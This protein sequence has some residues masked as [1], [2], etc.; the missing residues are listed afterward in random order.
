MLVLGL[1]PGLA[2]TG[3][4]LVE[5][6]GQNLCPVTYGVIR[7]PA[8]TPLADRLVELQ[9]RLEEII[10]SYRPEVAAV[11]EL[12]FSTNVRT[13]I[14]V[15]QARG[16]ALLTVARAGLRVVEYTPMQIKQGITGYGKADKLQVQRMVRLLLNLDELPRPDDAADALA[17]AVCCHHGARLETLLQQ[18]RGR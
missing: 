6:D 4:G 2:I 13:A 15:A 12:F 18:G 3:Y 16:V 8:K 11:E 7:T 17:V 5:G 9:Q 10:G 1:D 14:M